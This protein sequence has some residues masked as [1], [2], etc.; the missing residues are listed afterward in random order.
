MYFVCVYLCC[1]CV[2]PS[3]TYTLPDVCCK[4]LSVPCLCALFCPSPCHFLINL[5]NNYCNLYAARY[6]NYFFNIASV[7]TCQPLLSTTS[8]FRARALSL[9][10]SRSLRRPTSQRSSW[11]APRPT[12]RGTA[13]R[14][15]QEEQ[16]RP[17]HGRP[18]EAQAC[19]RT[20]ETQPARTGRTRGTLKPSYRYA[21]ADGA[22]GESTSIA[23]AAAASA[24]G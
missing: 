12:S 9:P 4:R 1:V 3:P 24:T 23:A 21:A 18:R 11:R 6:E 20:H 15:T 17:D 14:P 13:C 2:V 22:G 19:R 5:K 7:F 8:T 10:P 16:T